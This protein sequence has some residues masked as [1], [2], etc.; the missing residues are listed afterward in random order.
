MPL[1]LV[2]RLEEIDLKTVET[3]SG[4]PVVQYRGRLM[5]LIG[6]TEAPLQLAKDGRQPVLVFADRERSMGLV[7]DEIL[8]IVEDRI[9]VEISAKKPGIL[10]TSVI[11]GTAMDIIDT[12]YYLTQAF[13][14]WFIANNQAETAGHVPQILVIDDSAFFR[15]LL[16]PILSAA[17]FEVTALE[18]AT[19]ALARRDEGQMF[20]LIVSDIDM[21]G[22]NGL[23]FVKQARSGGEWIKLPIIALTA[24][25]SEVDAAKGKAAGFTEYVPKFDRDQIVATVKEVLNRQPKE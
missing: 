25:A 21:P 5:P 1:G 9:N 20:D 16:T 18:S 24:R 8:D 2:A 12:G 6:M 23:D 10:G 7:V 3:S 4:K 15:N 14:D 13:G 11:K 22:M 17:G 19:E